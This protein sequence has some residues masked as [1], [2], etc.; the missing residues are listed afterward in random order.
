MRFWKTS[1]NNKKAKLDIMIEINDL[2]QKIKNLE[3]EINEFR[4]TP[5]NKI[6]IEKL[7]EHFRTHHIYHSAGIEGNRLTMAETAIVLKEG[8]DISGKP[9][10]D[11]IEVKNLGLAFL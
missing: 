1:V 8:I 7:R 9:L 5:L 3:L 6:A 11:S 2:T 10:K 4:D